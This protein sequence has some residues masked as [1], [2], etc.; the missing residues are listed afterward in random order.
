MAKFYNKVHMSLITAFFGFL[1]IIPTYS[2]QRI[3]PAHQ[4]EGDHSSASVV[5]GAISTAPACTLSLGNQDS[6]TRKSTELLSDIEEI[7]RLLKDS[8]LCPN[9]TIP[10]VLE[11]HLR[12]APA[13]AL[14][15]VG[16]ERVFMTAAMLENVSEVYA[17]DY[18]EGAVLFNQINI[19]LLAIAKNMDDYRRLRMNPALWEERLK[20][21][22]VHPDSSRIL[23]DP[24]NRTLWT[25][26]VTH[27]TESGFQLLHHP[28][29]SGVEQPGDGRVMADPKK[30]GL[31]GTQE[32]QDLEQCAMVN[33]LYNEKYFDRLQKLAKND[34]I[35]VKK[36]DLKQSLDVDSFVSDVKKS[37]PIAVL[38]V[39]NA[40]TSKYISK[41]HRENLIK[42]FLNRA[43][44]NSQFILTH[45][46]DISLPT[47]DPRR[48]PQKDKQFE[49]FPVHL[50][51]RFTG[52][53]STNFSY[54]VFTKKYLEQKL[55]QQGDR[56][57][58]IMEFL[59]DVETSHNT[60]RA[61]YFFK[62]MEEAV[63]LNPSF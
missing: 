36:L 39:S 56:L 32:A 15:A 57:V 10:Q 34:K 6:L 13:G 16:T 21:S 37:S 29:H 22:S 48:D 44:E 61:R 53:Y 41:I 5:E 4:E 59:D 19:A 40:W 20:S 9:E 31:H 35:H 3:A 49:G 50:R 54:L 25:I 18:D 8:F 55:T 11:P 62:K 2:G 52:H 14:V 26:G 58:D 46:V 42:I 28:P 33:Y 30:T 24:R 60:P 45:F 7:Q 38:D 47:D 23:G 17:V 12:L 27:S 63:L 43:L 51:D 1:W